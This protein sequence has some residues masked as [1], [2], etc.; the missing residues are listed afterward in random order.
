MLNGLSFVE[1]FILKKINLKQTLPLQLDITNSCNL[2]CKHCY[3]PDHKNAGNLSL[4]N[5]FDIVDQYQNL[6]KKYTYKSKIILC[7]G[8][9]FVS[10][11]LWPILDK[12]NNE[13]PECQISILTNATLIDKNV[14]QKLKLYKNIQLQ[15]SLDGS[16]AKTHNFYRG[17]GSFEKSVSAIKLL[18]ENGFKVKI[19]AVLSRNK[20]NE[21]DSFFQLAKTLQVYQMNF[22]RLVENGA[23]KN[24]VLANQDSSL[25]GLDL[26]DAYTRII[27][28]SIK[29][30]VPTNLQK[31]L[32]N[33]IIPGLGRNGKFWEAIIVD[34]KGNILASSRSR[35]VLGSAL[36]DGLE[37]VFVEHPLM[38]NLRK[39]NIEKCG[40]CPHF[41]VCGGDRNAAFASTGN[42]LAADPG[43]WIHEEQNSNVLK[44]VINF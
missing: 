41:N 24:M 25:V 6:I 22:T 7:G 28:S 43:C 20:L 15:V 4:N 38:V 2:S 5:W 8:E 31:P 3:H 9:P 32:M 18:I 30:Q 35:L 44:K 29:Y 27:S 1:R 12:L 11:Y 21:L 36:N 13:M 17:N 19:L 40:K 16:T 37:K 10:P 26:K 42:F 23:G 33:L 39:G 14:I 34:F